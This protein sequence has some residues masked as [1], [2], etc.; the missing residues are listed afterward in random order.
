MSSKRKKAEVVAYEKYG[1]RRD[2]A[3]VLVGTLKPLAAVFVPSGQEPPKA[4]NPEDK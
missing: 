2:G 3:H 4:T 1:Y